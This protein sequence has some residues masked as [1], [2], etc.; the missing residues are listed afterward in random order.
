MRPDL[1]TEQEIID[2]LQEFPYWKLDGIKIIRELV[3]NNFVAAIGFVNS[4]AIFAENLNH[5]P[6][7]TI[8]GWNKLRISLTTFD[9]GGLTRLDFELAAKIETLLN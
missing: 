5:H 3:F 7:L 4:I 9:K 1:L 8:Y 2:N 6:D